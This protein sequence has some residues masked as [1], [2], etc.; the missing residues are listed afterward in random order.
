MAS[1]S[2]NQL[3]NGLKL[4]IDQDPCVVVDCEFT[5]PGKGQAFTKVKVKNLLKGSVTEKS[6]R[7]SDSVEGA[8]VV[9]TDMQFLYNDGSSWH[10]MN[11]DTFEQ[12]SADATAMGDAAQWIKEQ[13]VCS[14]TLWNGQPILVTPPNFVELEVTETDPGVRGDTSSGG[15]KPATLETSAVVK[16][17]L[18]IQIGEKLK[19]DTRSGE[20]VS[21]AKD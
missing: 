17:P 18:F 21:R 11:P 19:V 10:F 1:Y 16:V 7:S 20:Y 5:K 9:D 3:K 2:M 4:L 6:Y 13:D 12:V 8:D 14:V 15:T